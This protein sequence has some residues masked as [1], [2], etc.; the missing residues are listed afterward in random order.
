MTSDR[1]NAV[2]RSLLPEYEPQNRARIPQPERELTPKQQIEVSAQATRD[3]LLAD[4]N[5]VVGNLLTDPS[6][7]NAPISFKRQMV[8][9]WER[10]VLPQLQSNYSDPEDRRLVRSS[11]VPRLR[12]FVSTEQTKIDEAPY[13]QDDALARGFRMLGQA[14]NN[15]ERLYNAQQLSRLNAAERDIAAGIGVS[16]TSI[17]AGSVDESVALGLLGGISPQAMARSAAMDIDNRADSIVAAETQA[18][19]FRQ[20]EDR[21]YKELVLN[22]AGALDNERQREFNIIQGGS[23]GDWELSTSLP[24]GRM[25]GNLASVFLENAP[26]TLASLAAGA[27]TGVA[28]GGAAPAMAAASLLGAGLGA[29]QGYEELTRRVGMM[30]DF[31]LAEVPAYVD[32]VN[33]GVSP[34]MAKAR[35]AVQIGADFAPVM[36]LIEGAGSAL[37]LEGLILGNPLVRSLALKYGTGFL[38]RAAGMTVA[39]SV[40]EGLE[41]VGQGAVTNVATNRPAMEGAGENFALGAV[42]SLPFAGA[43]GALQASRA[44]GQQA[45]LDA[46]AQA[47]AQQRAAQQVEQA[48]LFRRLFPD[49]SPEGDPQVQKQIQ[50]L[51]QARRV[52][53]DQVAFASENYGPTVASQ[54]QS[55]VAEQVREIDSRL[56]GLSQQLHAAPQGAQPTP[57]A[58]VIEVAPGRYNLPDGRAVSAA[59]LSVLARVNPT[60]TIQTQAGLM[61]LNSWVNG[62]AVPVLGGQ[63]TP[64]TPLSP[65]SES[66]PAAALGVSAGQ[67]VQTA[68]DMPPVS[69]QPSVTTPEAASPSQPPVAARFSPTQREERISRALEAAGY[70]AE[71]ATDVSILINGMLDSLAQITG[72]DVNAVTE[73][74]VSIESASSDL[75]G[76]LIANA[77]GVYQIL[78]GDNANASTALHEFEHL[79]ILEALRISAL[80]VDQVADASAQA[81]LRTDLQRLNR[82][83]GGDGQVW[84][85]AQHEAVARGFEAYVRT[86]KAPVSWMS[87]IFERMKN[88]LRVIYDSVSKLGVGLLTDD[89]REVFDRQILGHRTPRARSQLGGATNIPNETPYQTNIRRPAPRTYQYPF[90]GTEA[91]NETGRRE[92]VD[93]ANTDANISMEETV[94]TTA[95]AVEPAVPVETVEAGA[96]APIG[97]VGGQGGTDAGQA[98]TNDG[99]NPAVVSS[100][101]DATARPGSELAGAASDGVAADTG[102]ERLDELRPVTDADQTS[103]GGDVVAEWESRLETE[104]LGVI[105]GTNETRRQKARREAQPF[106]EA[107]PPTEAVI[108]EDPIPSEEKEAQTAE[109]LTGISGIRIPESQFYV[110]ELPGISIVDEILGLSGDGTISTAASTY[111]DAV[112]PAGAS[113]VVSAQYKRPFTTALMD[114]LSNPSDPLRKILPRNLWGTLRDRMLSSGVAV[115]MD[116][117]SPVA[118]P[119][120]LAVPSLDKHGITAI[121]ES[122][123][124]GPRQSV[125]LYDRDTNQGYALS[126]GSEPADVVIYPGISYKDGQVLRGTNMSRAK[127]VAPDGS[128]K[129]LEVG[130]GSFDSAIFTD[131]SYAAGAASASVEELN[132]ELAELDSRIEELKTELAAA[133]TD[134]K[135]ALRK[136]FTRLSHRRGKVADLIEDPVIG[137]RL[138][139]F[140]GLV[141]SIGSKTNILGD[142]EA[143]ITLFQGEVPSSINLYTVPGAEDAAVAQRLEETHGRRNDANLFDEKLHDPSG[144]F[145]DHS[146]GQD[147]AVLARELLAQVEPATS[148]LDSILEILAD[149][150]NLATAPAP[151]LPVAIPEISAVADEFMRAPIIPVAPNDLAPD[152][153]TNHVGNMEEWKGKAV[154]FRAWAEDHQAPVRNW[155]IN[156]L[157]GQDRDVAVNRAMSLAPERVRRSLSGMLDDYYAPVMRFAYDQGRA[158]KKQT[159][160]VVKQLETAATAYHI[161]Q[162]GAEAHERMLIDEVTRLRADGAPV[163]ALALAQA[164]AALAGYRTYQAN[165]NAEKVPVPGGMRTADRIKQWQ[166]AVAFFGSEDTLL[167]GVRSV[168]RAYQGVLQERLANNTITQEEF[169]QINRFKWYVSTA[170]RQEGNLAASNDAGAFFLNPRRQDYRRMGSRTAADGSIQLLLKAMERTAT[171]IGMTAFVSEVAKVYNSLN[172]QD[173]GTRGLRMIDEKLLRKMA[174]SNNSFENQYARQTRES[175]GL[176]YHYRDAKGQRQTSRIVFEGNDQGFSDEDAARLN[177]ALGFLARPNDLLATVAGVT[178]TMSQFYTLWRPMFA[179]INAMRDMPERMFTTLGSDF[180]KADG[181]TVKGSTIIATMASNALNPL[182]MWEYGKAFLG[183]AGNSTIGRMYEEFKKSGGNYSYSQYLNQGRNSFETIIKK[184]GSKLA[185]A[186]N[187]ITKWSDFFNSFPAFLQYAAFRENGVGASDSSA[188]TLDT[189]NFHKTGTSTPVLSAWAPFLVST[190]QTGANL[191]RVLT[192]GGNGSSAARTRAWA[193][194]GG[195]VMAGSMLISALRAGADDDESGQNRYDLLSFD[196]LSRGIPLIGSGGDIVHVPIGFGGPMLAWITANAAQRLNDGLITPAEAAYQM[197]FATLRTMTPG[198]M[199]SY[200]PG[201]NPS[202]WLLQFITPHIIRPIA[203]LAVNKNNWGSAISSTQFKQIG[204]RYYEMGRATTPEVYHDMA[205]TVYDTIG[206]DFAPEALRYALGFYL[207]GMLQAPL[208]ALEQDD[209]NSEMHKNTRSSLGPILSGL[210]AGTMYSTRMNAAQSAYYQRKQAI[211]AELNDKGVRVSKAAKA[212][213]ENRMLMEEAGFDYAVIDEYIKLLDLERQLQKLDSSFKK[214][215]YGIWWEQDPDEAKEAFAEW[216]ESR[217]ALLNSVMSEIGRR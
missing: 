200:P 56:A 211:E 172:A 127:V 175:G 204:Q 72:G 123:G 169:D 117:L 171:E 71:Y 49:L 195:L 141:L 91:I 58:T 107:G 151:G 105:G 89:V 160:D 179:P 164:E 173:G 12:E 76:A 145:M 8:D 152:Q 35:L 39:G 59:N 63:A 94:E 203:D 61:D 165:P 65:N 148:S 87:G 44:G 181:S 216:A 3:K 27:V 126:V 190:V 75:T 2:T 115:S 198:S 41:E 16:G 73:G 79:Y 4:M 7:I 130:V 90:L 196:Q 186:K 57:T 182:Y 46:L 106:I 214:N 98:Q 193:T 137:P 158:L 122:L 38:A 176:L 104:G 81:A 133:R 215:N 177:K 166:D 183:K 213:Q 80:P 202:A 1:Y 180:K 30:T 60:A 6:F 192:Q 143:G 163:N 67:S 88:L 84:N 10:D 197:T 184:Q 48:A 134:E 70:G 74:R 118:L 47:A 62:E 149:V 139:G 136:E 103:E 95:P 212:G 153:A 50:S 28:T 191:I 167:E 99:N 14:P 29:A 92:E 83:A 54:V 210:G 19:R 24:T 157:G 21:I 170:T 178:R 162:E 147:I 119:Q 31:E 17:P 36:G 124:I 9:A 161:I 78:F 110:D 155:F 40:A 102:A 142:E 120:E 121:L 55:R 187:I 174:S 185:A 51:E 82:W 128:F 208:M 93:S 42:A 25:L 209:M 101:P 77:R 23:G 68:Q 26:N 111:D 100:A 34:D 159:A 135:P 207:P 194:F 154:A 11:T 205:R 114:A 217:N 140:R 168:V 199:P 201:E 138:K 131:Q 64:Q 33:S 37:G 20:D 43:G 13:L 69:T 96:A 32:M 108:E 146:Q 5:S 85:E 45:V 132:S 144:G 150:G 97:G 18:Q 189:M 125:L 206:L 112:E 15:L 66:Q 86:G 129:S 113:E 109:L 188:Y 52:L 22:N 116:K 53:T 156:A